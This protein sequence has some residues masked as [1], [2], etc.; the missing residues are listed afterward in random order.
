MPWRH[1]GHPRMWHSLT[2]SNLP[3]HIVWSEPTILPKEPRATVT[4]LTTLS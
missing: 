4:I 1:V 2:R 3:L